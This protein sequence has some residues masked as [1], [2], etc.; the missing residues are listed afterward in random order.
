MFGSIWDN[1]SK[2][3][4]LPSSSPSLKYE[5]RNPNSVQS[6]FFLFKIRHDLFEFCSVH[7]FQRVDIILLFVCVQ[8][9]NKT[10]NVAFSSASPHKRWTVMAKTQTLSCRLSWLSDTSTSNR[11]QSPFD[12]SNHGL[13]C[14]SLLNSV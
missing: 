6:L 5:S 3:W 8:F 9:T 4:R 2:T 13:S 12:M 10:Y 7:C 14:L 11:A 1:R